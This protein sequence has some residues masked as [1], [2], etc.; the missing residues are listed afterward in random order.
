MNQVSESIKCKGC[1]GRDLYEY[2]RRLYTDTNIRELKA[3]ADNW[4]L[5]QHLIE[6]AEMKPTDFPST[7]AMLEAIQ[8]KAKNAAD[9]EDDEDE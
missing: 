6:I 2:Y 9:P 7:E 5:A 1:G 8:K 3:L 4:A